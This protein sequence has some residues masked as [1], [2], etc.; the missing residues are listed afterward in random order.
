SL[1]VCRTTPEYARLALVSGRDRRKRV[2]ISVAAA[3]RLPIGPI[4]TD[5]GKGGMNSPA[6]K[7]PSPFAVSR[8]GFLF[9]VGLFPGS[10]ACVC[11]GGGSWASGLPDPTRGMATIRDRL[12][13]WPHDSFTLPLRV[14]FAP[15]SATVIAIQ[16][17]LMLEARGGATTDPPAGAAAEA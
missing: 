13:H 4:C 6:V 2:R 10:P 8:W 17:R 16:Q 1:Y 14:G 9:A 3:G 11:A 12:G 15:C 5:V 7:P